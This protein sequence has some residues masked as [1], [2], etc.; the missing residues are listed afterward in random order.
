MPVTNRA[1]IQWRGSLM[2]KPWPSGRSERASFESRSHP[3]MMAALRQESKT[4]AASTQPDG[5]IAPRQ[6]NALSGPSI[7]RSASSRPLHE[8][9]LHGHDTL[10]RLAPPRPAGQPARGGDQPLPAAARVQPG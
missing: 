3:L 4:E 8:Y 2:A 1:L 9:D 6:Y 10:R 5:R 7:K